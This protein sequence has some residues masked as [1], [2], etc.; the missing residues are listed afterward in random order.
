MS[1]ITLVRDENGHDGIATFAAPGD[2]GALVFQDEDA[3]WSPSGMVVGGP[4]ADPRLSDKT[5]EYILV[6]GLKTTLTELSKV[7]YP[8]QPDAI[9]LTLASF[10]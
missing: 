5:E 7:V 9:Q 6:C 1:N 3:Y 10:A 4:V 8:E 2:S